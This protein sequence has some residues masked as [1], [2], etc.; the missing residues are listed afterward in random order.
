MYKIPNNSPQAKEP[1]FAAESAVSAFAVVT[2]LSKLLNDPLH[3]PAE[4]S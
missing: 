1:G 4:H 2:V 3:L